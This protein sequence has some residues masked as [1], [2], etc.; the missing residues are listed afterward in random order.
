MSLRKLNLYVME[1]VHNQ[2]DPPRYYDRKM[3]LYILRDPYVIFSYCLGIFLVVGVPLAGLYVQI[4]N[5]PLR[6]IF[7]FIGFAFG[8]LGIIGPMVSLRR[9][10]VGIRHGR[11][12]SAEAV[13]VESMGDYAVSGTWIVRLPEC[14][15]TEK[16]MIIDAQWAS[17]IHEGS[18]F[19]VLLHP[20][21]NKI[22][23]P[24]DI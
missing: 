15:I 18:H 2:P 23:I 13:K 5:N 11:I 24:L 22:L 8:L 21:R 17:S 19:R 3:L 12:A 14:T 10:S 7:Y 20:K 16:K 9:W 1:L 6:L 4:W